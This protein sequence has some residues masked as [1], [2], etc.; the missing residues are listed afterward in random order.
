[1][2]AS[3]N[4]KQKWDDAALNYQDVFKL[5]INEYNARLLRFWQEKGMLF[6]GCRVI[7]IGCGVGKYGTYLASLGCD[8]TLTDISE[9]MIRHARENMA[10][11][12]TPWAAV[13]CDFN[14]ITGEEEVFARGF[15]LAISTMSPAIH[16]LDTVRKMSS[17]THGRCFVARF[18]DW[19]QPLRDELMM[20]ADIT[21]KSRFERPLKLD[22]EDMLN[23]VRD[24][25]FTPQVE[26][27]DYNWADKRSID[28]MAEYMYRNYFADESNGAELK[29]RIHDIITEK[30][31]AEGS[32]NDC[33]NTKVAWIY[34]K[35]EEQA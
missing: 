14:E 16:D 15:D 33:V 19:E 25:G 12:S 1:M 28:E 26:Y 22:C 4:E 30:Y 10:R 35:T 23:A 5:G 27:V 3:K 6:P 7:D 18:Y 31:G 2:Y 24:A 8:V 11:F 32:V 20:S 13:C 34:W 21:P 29:S 9:K 17:M